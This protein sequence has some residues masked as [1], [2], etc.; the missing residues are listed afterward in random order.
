MRYTI[1][2]LLIILALYIL[3]EIIGEALLAYHHWYLKREARLSKN[4]D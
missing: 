4:H 2:C 1:I 3:R